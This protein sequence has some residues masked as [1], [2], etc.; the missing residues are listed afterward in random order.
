MS[1]SYLWTKLNSCLET[2]AYEAIQLYIVLSFFCYQTFV[3][4]DAEVLYNLLLARAHKCRSRSV[5][6]FWLD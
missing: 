6:F 4:I 3:I 1:D 2:I 5:P